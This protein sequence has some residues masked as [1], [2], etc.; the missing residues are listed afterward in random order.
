MISIHFRNTEGPDAYQLFSAIHPT[1]ISSFGRY[2]SYSMRIPGRKKCHSKAD[3]A[4]TR[5]QNTDEFVARDGAVIDA[6]THPGNAL[7][8][9][10][11]GTCHN[12]RVPK[13]PAQVWL[14]MMAPDAILASMTDGIM[15][16]QAAHLN[17]D[18]K[19]KITE[20]L[21]RTSLA[22]YQPPAPPAGCPT[23]RQ[24][25]SGPAPARV[26]WGH[27]TSRYIPADIAGLSTDDVASLELKWAFAFP[28]AVRA[29]SQPAIGWNTVFVGSQDGTVYAFDL[30]T[31]CAKWTTRVSAEVRT[32][33]V[34][35]PDTKRLYF[36][37]F[38]GRAYAVDAMTG[39]E[40]WRTKVDNHP[41]ATITGTPTLGGGRLFVPVS[42]LEV[43]SAADPSYA[44]CTFRGALA[45]L[46]PASG[47]ILWK[48]HTIPEAPSEYGET[49]AGTPNPRTI[50]RAG[51]ERADL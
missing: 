41:N 43:T 35:D 44:C 37:D 5:V 24:N 51:L 34:A 50:R 6:T 38:L 42:S 47:E 27:E 29:R 30:E 22:D 45:A 13:A 49:S 39:Q 2:W 26:G 11:C 40:I 7:F 3:A 9:E 32:G 8:M 4:Q 28:S 36:G 21:T 18:E 48:T 14:E 15:T 33:I 46:D 20:F 16:A 17:S 10:N 19:T 31:G 1:S 25:F 12:G 23:S